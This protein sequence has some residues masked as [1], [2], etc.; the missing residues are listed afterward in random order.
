MFVAENVLLLRLKHCWYI[1]QL[2]FN[3]VKDVSCVALKGNSTI[4]YSNDQLGLLLGPTRHAG[5]V[6]VLVKYNTT[7]TPTRRIGH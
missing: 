3:P 2:S 5:K 7:T 1:L 4:M 6:I